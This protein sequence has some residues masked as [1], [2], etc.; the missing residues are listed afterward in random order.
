MELT[1]PQGPPAPHLF[2]E[3]AQTTAHMSLVPRGV[4]YDPWHGRP[5][6][7]GSGCCSPR[8]VPLLRPSHVCRVQMYN[9]AMSAGLPKLPGTEELVAPEGPGTVPSGRMFDAVKLNLPSC[10]VLKS[11]TW[12]GQSRH[13]GVTLC[14]I[15]NVPLPRIQHPAV[16]PKPQG[17]PMLVAHLQPEGLG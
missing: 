3:T 4:Q 13:G 14:S 16:V 9:C 15:C 7:W 6:P 5:Q 11:R 10:A 17:C 2:P 1:A 12:N 8:S